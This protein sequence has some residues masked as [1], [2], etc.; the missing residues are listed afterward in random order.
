MSEKSIQI[1]F[2]KL[3]C[4]IT[5]TFRAAGLSGQDARTGADVLAQTD[6]WGVFT[7]GTKCLP[8]LLQCLKA[9]GLTGC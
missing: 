5:D 3:H 1:S 2:E 7:H 9:G 4:F 6:A 8:R